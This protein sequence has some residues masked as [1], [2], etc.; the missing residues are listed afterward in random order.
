M[1]NL[2][3]LYIIVSILFLNCATAPPSQPRPYGVD[4]SIEQAIPYLQVGMQKSKVL[5]LVGY[6]EDFVTRSLSSF[7]LT[8]IYRVKTNSFSSRSR[9]YITFVDGK[10]SSWT[11]Y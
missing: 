10:L 11:I 8:E 6:D 3:I 5:V 4:G 7:G 1:R 2:F 9:A